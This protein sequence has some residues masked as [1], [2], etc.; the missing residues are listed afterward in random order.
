MRV[1]VRVT[2]V[3]LG[4]VKVRVRVMGEVEMKVMVGGDVGSGGW[5]VWM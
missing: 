3:A 5:W 2:V 4:E 1:V